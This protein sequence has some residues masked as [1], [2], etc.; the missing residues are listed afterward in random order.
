MALKSQLWSSSTLDHG[1][2]LAHMASMSLENDPDTLAMLQELQ[3]LCQDLRRWDPHSRYICICI[4]LLYSF[5]ML[6][7]LRPRERKRERERGKEREREKDKGRK[8]E[9]EKEREREGEKE[10]E[11]ERER[12]RKRDN[13]SDKF[14]SSA[15][16]EIPANI[17]C[18][19]HSI[20]L[21][22]VTG[23]GLL[24]FKKSRSGQRARPHIQKYREITSERERERES[25]SETEADPGS[26]LC[27]LAPTCFEERQVERAR[28]TKRFST[29][30]IPEWLGL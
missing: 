17:P 8:K 4:Y 26:N 19:P 12:E 3:E 6:V 21:Q 10:K 24:M 18:A 23:H 16:L 9:R 29:C 5:Y 1:L 27:I 28:E 7:G 25:K 15:I 13:M 14:W 11:R 30:K 2:R 20:G 22:L